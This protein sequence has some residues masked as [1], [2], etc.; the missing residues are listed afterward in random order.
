MFTRWTDFNQ[1]LVVLDEF[2]RRMNRMF[3][4]FDIGQRPNVFSHSAVSWPTVN[5]YDLGKELSL[6]GVFIPL[7]CRK[8]ALFP[9]NV[10]PEK[11]AQK[12]HDPEG[13][14]DQPCYHGVEQGG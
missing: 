14:Q 8:P 10:L 2:Q 9:F 3:Y 6:K 5:L 1:S 11:S 13:Q 12:D 4:E 7:H